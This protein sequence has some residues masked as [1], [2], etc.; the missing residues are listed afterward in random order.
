M[1]NHDEN[2]GGAGDAPAPLPELLPRPSIKVPLPTKFT[3]EVKDLKPE[4]SNRWYN[5]VQLYLQLNRVAQNVP[6]SGNYWILYTEGRAQEAAF[7]ATETFG[8][9]LNR[10]EF[11]LY[12]RETFQSSKHMDDIYQKFHSIRQSWNGQGHKK[13]QQLQHTCLCSDHDYQQILLVTILSHRNSLHV[14]TQGYARTRRS[15][16]T[17][18]ITSMKSL[19]LQKE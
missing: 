6:G 12:L 16:M 18:R 14:C 9:N 5:S 11:I 19:Q 10:N 2:A 7:Q 13:L 3:G 1:S 15:S 8:E 17:E 4:A